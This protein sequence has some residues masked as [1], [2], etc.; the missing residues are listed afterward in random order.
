M[1]IPCFAGRVETEGTVMQSAAWGTICP[2]AWSFMLA[3]RARGLGAS[4]TCLHLMFEQEA[5]AL[6][7]IPFADIQQA[8]LLT[9][10]HTK[11]TAFKP[12]WRE[13]VD[14]IVHWETW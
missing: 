10:A 1:V 9:V 4:W 5:A 13:P 12:A 14:S 7:G 11:G 6:L 8:C 3:L 2:A